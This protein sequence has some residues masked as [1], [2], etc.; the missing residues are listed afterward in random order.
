MTKLRATK[1][2]PWPIA[3][4][5]LPLLLVSC[6]TPDVGSDGDPDDAPTDSVTSIA[7]EAYIY[8]FPLL[9]SY[10]MMFAQV[11]SVD[12]GAPFN[13]VFHNTSL[14][15]PD[16]TLIVRPNNDTLYPHPLRTPSSQSDR[17]KA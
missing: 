2:M 6:V 13:E 16:Y 15:G 7:E 9:E 17:W 1:A 8:T 11:V 10:K 12:S 5:A 14:L 4:L 3:I